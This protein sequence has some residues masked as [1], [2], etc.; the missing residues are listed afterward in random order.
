MATESCSTSRS[1]EHT[2]ELQSPMYLVC[3]PLLEKK[4]D[5]NACAFTRLIPSP[6]SS[7]SCRTAPA[8][9][10][11]DRQPPPSRILLRPADAGLHVLGAVV[12]AHPVAVE[13]YLEARGT[14]LAAER[15]VLTVGDHQPVLVQL[16]SEPGTV[17]LLFHAPG[18]HPGATP[19]PYTTLFR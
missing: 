4:Q 5:R 12:A 9:H 8:P 15:E 19:F 13:P 16:H 14:D 17:D 10:A 7:E 11:Q 2:S 18:D 3:R 6:P 1:E